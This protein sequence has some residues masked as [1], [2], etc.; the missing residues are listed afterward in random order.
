MRRAALY[1]KGED[2]PDRAEALTDLPEDG[3]DTLSRVDR[4]PAVVTRSVDR[5]LSAAAEAQF[6]E[7]R[8]RPG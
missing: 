5:A 2:M 8:G 1:M 6:A 3:I 4:A 7:R